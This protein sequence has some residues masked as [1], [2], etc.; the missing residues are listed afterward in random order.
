VL[1]RLGAA[2]VAMEAIALVVALWA[3]GSAVL[4]AGAPLIVGTVILFAVVGLSE[5]PRRLLREHRATRF[6][7]DAVQPEGLMSGFFEAPAPR[8]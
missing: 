6:D 1:V 7:P 2:V 3:F 4:L 8:P 5:G